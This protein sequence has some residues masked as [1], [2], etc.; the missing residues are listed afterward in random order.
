MEQICREAGATVRNFDIVRSSTDARRFE[1]VA[2]GLAVFGG[3]PSA[4][5]AILVSA[6]HCD[7]T[8][9]KK[10]DMTNVTAFQHAR[11]RK[12]DRCP[13][14]AVLW[15]ERV[16]SHCWRSRRKVVTRSPLRMGKLNQP[17]GSRVAVHKRRGTAGG[18]VYCVFCCE[19]IRRRTQ[20]SR[21]LWMA[22]PC[23]DRVV[24]E[25]ARCRK[26][27]TY[28]EL[29]P[30]RRARLVAI[31]VGG[32]MSTETISFLNQLAKARSRQETANMRRRVE[33]A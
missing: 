7:G 11:K 32:R 29:G 17:Q 12:E 22:S 18:A 23:L 27:R 26:E 4:I 21:W 14:C 3:V 6:H 8:P 33:Q 5:D 28:P 30:R 15:R 13:N 20:G 19:G 10:A 31:E 24:L 25:R 9:L 16:W 2:E 1:V